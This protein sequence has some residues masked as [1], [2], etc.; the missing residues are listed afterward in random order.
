MKLEEVARAAVAEAAYNFHMEQKLKECHSLEGENLSL[1]VTSNEQRES[2]P[3][4]VEVCTRN[5]S[6]MQGGVAAVSLTIDGAT[7]Q[8]SEVLHEG[9]GRIPRDLVPLP[10]GVPTL[11]WT[12]VC[13]EEKF[14]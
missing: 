6:S 7:P 14:P 11:L 3:E 12:R 4:D 8:N 13:L 10:R 5:K 2:V 1:E 9:G